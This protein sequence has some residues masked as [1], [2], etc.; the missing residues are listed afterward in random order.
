MG[1]KCIFCGNKP[2]NKNLEHIIPLWLIKHTGDPKRIV[3][4][5]MHF[6]RRPNETQPK[7]FA[8][9]QFRF[10][11][12]EA[13]NLRWSDLENDIKHTVIKLENEQKVTE[14]ELS[15]FLDWFDKV[16]VGIWLARQMDKSTASLVDPKFYIDQRVGTSDRLLYISSGS[17]SQGLTTI[18][19][20]GA[21]FGFMPS[22]FAL[23]INSL[24]F[25]NVSS[26]GLFG[27]RLGFPRLYDKA[28]QVKGERAYLPWV[29]SGSNQISYPIVH[30]RY[31]LAALKLY[32]PMYRHLNVHHF[33]QEN[34]RT[35]YVVDNSLDWSTGAGGIFWDT[36][37]SAERVDELTEQHYGSTHVMSGSRLGEQVANAVSKWQNQLSRIGFIGDMESPERRRQYKETMEKARKFDKMLAKS[38]ER[39]ERSKTSDSD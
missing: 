11:S 9:D 35:P 39:A 20:G 27:H 30:R 33:W 14:V 7:I 4:H 38:S 17:A 22:V 1:K 34:Y 8:F 25:F 16:R 10:P 5:G 28:T 6:G 26:A 37:Y 36:G 23:R 32:Q 24:M 12:C 2:E 19:V 18:G 21:L 29:D 13:C 3:Y 15:Q 31:P